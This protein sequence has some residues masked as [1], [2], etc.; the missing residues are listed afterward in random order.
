[1]GFC[2]SI[3]LADA[4][5]SPVGVDDDGCDSDD[6]FPWDFVVPGFVAIWPDDFI[7]VCKFCLISFFEIFF[8]DFRLSLDRCIFA[9]P[10]PIVVIIVIETKY[11]LA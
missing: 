7:V 8:P 3:V 4:I 6:V 10:P 5:G 9:V 2:D 1:V 11:F